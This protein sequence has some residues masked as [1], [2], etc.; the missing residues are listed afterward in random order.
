M[1]EIAIKYVAVEIAPALTTV[2]VAKVLI[3]EPPSKPIGLGE[4]LGLVLFVINIELNGGV[5]TN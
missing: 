5:C 4:N 2:L 1:I 3:I